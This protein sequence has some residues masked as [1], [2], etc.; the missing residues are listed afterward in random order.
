MSIL[1]WAL[2]L[3][4]AAAATHAQRA[5]IVMADQDGVWVDVVHDAHP[6]SVVVEVLY[7]GVRVGAGE[8]RVPA[9]GVASAVR[10]LCGWTAAGRAM[11]RQGIPLELGLRVLQGTGGVS[12]MPAAG[13]YAPPSLEEILRFFEGSVQ[14]TAIQKM[15]RGAV[16]WGGQDLAASAWYRLRLLS[17]PQADGCRRPSEE[18]YARWSADLISRLDGAE[19]L[20]AE[21]LVA[22]VPTRVWSGW[23]YRARQIHRG[24]P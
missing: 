12:R 10:L 7:G 8:W 1:R 13:R 18:E 4:F 19:R 6:G 15:V 9:P 17:P 20:V 21:R 2:I 5:E 23:A 14:G 11:L 22:T 16:A 3:W 24:C